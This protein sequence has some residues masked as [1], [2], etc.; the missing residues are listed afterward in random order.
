MDYPD[1]IVRDNQDICTLV[2]PEGVV[3]V[4]PTPFY[5]FKNKRATLKAIK[6]KKEQRLT[7]V[8]GNFFL[9]TEERDASKQTNTRASYIRRSVSEGHSFRES[10]ALEYFLDL[11]QRRPGVD[12]MYS[13]E[14]VH[15]RI[16]GL[17]AVVAYAR[18]YSTLALQADLNND[19]SNTDD[20]W[21]HIGGDGRL[22]TCWGGGHRLSIA[23]IM[24]L[25]SIPV[26]I[27]LVHYDAYRDGIVENIL[28]RSRNFEKRLHE[29]IQCCALTTI[30]YPR[31]N[32]RR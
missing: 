8:K 29:R 22:I 26:R 27:G 31:K 1:F 16:D 6:F 11:L 5:K 30:Q 21:V 19:P 32:L 17:D 25:E 20:I 4:P 18:Q 28:A 15:K 24:G 13:E 9:M 14:D 23:Q 12:R 2:S 7:L 10:G 3:Y